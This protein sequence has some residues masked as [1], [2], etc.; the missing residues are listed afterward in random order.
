MQVQPHLLVL[1][2]HD[3][4]SDG[5]LCLGLLQLSQDSLL[6]Y[7]RVVVAHHHRLLRCDDAA[8]V[9]PHAGAH[10][11]PDS[12]VSRPELEPEAPT[13]Q[14]RQAVHLGHW[15]QDSLQLRSSKDHPVVV[16]YA[17]VVAYLRQH[18]DSYVTR[19]LLRLRCGE[20]VLIRKDQLL[21]RELHVAPVG[22][23]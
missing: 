1:A 7:D 3:S 23:G 9:H 6:G 20:L 22:D 14:G 4:P 8:H 13:G 12:G 10:I 16:Q 11:A 18:L 21:R 2:H 5:C 19:I 17:A 15:H